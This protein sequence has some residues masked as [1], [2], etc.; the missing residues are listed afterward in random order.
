MNAL[1]LIISIN[2]KTC[3]LD[4]YITP[5]VADWSGQLFI[6][7]ILY[8]KTSLQE[9]EPF[10]PMLDLF[11]LSLNSRKQVFFST[12]LFFEKLFYFVFDAH[13]KLAKK[14]CS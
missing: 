12:S 4:G 5:I 14:P 7:K 11:H 8:I 1:K 13:K 6:R 2:N 9:I 3:H 10:L